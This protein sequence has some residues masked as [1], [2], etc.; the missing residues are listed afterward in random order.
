MEVLEEDLVN[1]CDWDPLYLWNIFE[2]DF[3]DC[4]ELWG[5]SMEVNDTELVKN[6]EKMECYVPIV[7]DISLEDEVLSEAVQKIEDE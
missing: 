4:S 3:N 1:N 2:S 6:V 5:N 7:E